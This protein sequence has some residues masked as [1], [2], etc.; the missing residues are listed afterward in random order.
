MA[1]KNER[2][3]Q[4]IR[5]VWY[6]VKM[7]NGKRIKRAISTSKLEAQRIRDQWLK[8]ILLYGE[9]QEPEIELE[10]MLF[11]EVAK[12]W[13]T[14]K[15]KRIKL[16]T[17]RD[18]KGAMNYYVLPRFGNMPISEI[19]YLD[20]EKF[21]SDLNCTAKRVNNILVPMRSV[22]KFARTQRYIKENP[23]DEVKNLKVNKP[24]IF[25][26]AMEEVKRFFDQVNPSYKDF[27]VVAFFTGMRFGEMAALKWK[28]VDFRLGVIRIRETRVRGEEG[29]PKTGGSVRDIDMLTPVVKALRNQRRSTM[30]RSEYVFLNYYGRPLLPNSVNYHI[31]KPALKAAGLRPRSLYQTRHTFATLMLDGREH[32]GWVQRMMGHES[33]KMIFERYYSYI[34][35]YQHKPGSP[36]M[37]NVYIPIMDAAEDLEYMQDKKTNFTP[38]LHQTKKEESAIEANTSKSL[39]NASP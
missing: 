16:S 19:S 33:L 10:P 34:K 30:G 31:W 28:N 11:G 38:N 39:E 3:L 18:Y 24:D 2:N 37:K 7:V 8:E 21:I 26:L 9:I 36:F 32:P 13:V 35:D 4:K 27:F 6:F 29:R 12:L 5:N 25:P 22:F 23:M 14:T 17:L 20:V 15:E 1:R